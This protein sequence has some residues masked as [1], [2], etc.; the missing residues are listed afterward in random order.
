MSPHAPRPYIP[1]RV[2]SVFFTVPSPHPNDVTGVVSSMPQLAALMEDGI[3][4]SL[5][6]C[7][8]KLFMLHMMREGVLRSEHD[9]A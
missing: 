3:S 8:S 7:F 5:P 1:G 2:I 6:E 9:V 4:T